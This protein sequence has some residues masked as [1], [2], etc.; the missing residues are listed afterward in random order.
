MSVSAELTAQAAQALQTLVNLRTPT[1]V[2]PQLAPAAQQQ[3]QALRDQAANR[4][5]ELTF[6]TPRDEDWRFTDLAPLRPLAFQLPHQDALTTSIPPTLGVAIAQLSLSEV[7]CRVVLVNGRWCPELSDVTQ[8]PA[9]LT[10]TGLNLTGLNDATDLPAQLGQLIGAEEVWTTLNTASMSDAVFLQVQAPLA[11]PLHLIWVTL[12]ETGAPLLS[13][14]RCFVSVGTG[15]SLTLV[16]EFVGLG[17]TAHLTNSVNEISLAGNAQ[18]EHCRIQGRIQEPQ[19]PEGQI[20][21]KLAFQIGKTAVHQARDSRYICHAI[22]LGGAISRHNLDVHCTGP[23]TETT[24]NGLT[25]ALGEQLSDTHSSLVF[26]APHCTSH[27]IHKCIIGDR[28]RAVFN[29]KIVVP[30]V[31]QLTNANQLSRSL[32]LSN[33]ARID[34]KP[35]LEIVADN[36]K[37]THG[38]TVSQLSADEIFY[39]QS[40][41]LDYQ[42][43]T[44]LLVQGFALETLA[45]LPVASLRQSLATQ[46]VARLHPEM[47]SGV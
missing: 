7:P 27:Q 28:A 42:S 15:A 10:V 30:K 3:W 17:A 5:Q 11:Q 29:G 33:K 44:N 26:N 32:L 23:Q 12:A 2:T 43:A 47:S 46:I 13:H 18:L 31:A 38:A 8:L 34:T 4:T 39:L 37:C 40:R 41:G 1:L 24:M 14:P 22:S 20:A 35:Q 16:E 45:L 9:G 36:V 21:G 6:P 25:L 19:P